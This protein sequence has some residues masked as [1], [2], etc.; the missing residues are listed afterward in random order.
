MKQEFPKMIYH[1]YYGAKIVLNK[2]EQDDH[3]KNG[4]YE[5]YVVYQERNSI[6]N[7]IKWHLE[8]LKI[9]DAK[10][11]TVIIDESVDTS[12]PTVNSEEPKKGRR[13]RPR[14]EG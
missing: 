5:S 1:D 7:K 13:G 9:L 11:K 4:W 12:A 3:K 8:Q 14:K 10:S 2:E 6:E